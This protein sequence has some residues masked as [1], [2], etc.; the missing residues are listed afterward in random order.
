MT[1]EQARPRLRP[2]R[3]L[4]RHPV[5]LPGRV[6]PARVSRHGARTP[7]HGRDRRS[8]VGTGRYRLPPGTKTKRRLHRRTTQTDPDAGGRQL[9]FALLA[10]WLVDRDVSQ[11]RLAVVLPAWKVSANDTKPGVWIVYPS[12]SFLPLETRAFIS[13]LRRHALPERAC[14]GRTA[15]RARTG[16][17][18]RCIVQ[19]P[20]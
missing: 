9:G 14:P 18:L 6:L 12:R 13:L 2:R 11:D 1:G 17:H 19:G 7:A 10:D 5:L 8:R 20:A 15:L 3:G 4:G 16:S